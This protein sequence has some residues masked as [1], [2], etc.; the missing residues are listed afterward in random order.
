MQT[1][2]KIEPIWVNDLSVEPKRVYRYRLRLLV[3]NTY[4]GLTSELK[5]RQD[6]AKVVLLG[7]WS[8]WSQPIR[9]A[10]DR[11]LLASPG[12]SD[13]KEVKL[14]FRNWSEGNWDLTSARKTVGEP[15]IFRIGRETYNQKSVL[16]SVRT[17]V[18]YFDHTVRRGQIISREKPTTSVVLI[19]ADGEVEEH[20]TA[21]DSELKRQRLRADR[22]R[23]RLMRQYERM[24]GGRRPDEGSRR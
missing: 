22:A 20:L 24:S 5:D 6:A 11:Y 9:A 23:Q 14:E 7:Q 12:R 15:T 19:G 13:G 10:A 17:E 18:P 1:R 16:A 21:R 4:V 3:F 8:A 2:Q